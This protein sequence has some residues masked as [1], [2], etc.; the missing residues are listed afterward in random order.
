MMQEIARRA[1]WLEARYT[2]CLDREP[3][4]AYARVEGLEPSGRW[5]G[6]IRSRLSAREPL[7]LNHLGAYQ[8]RLLKTRPAK[9]A[10]GMPESYTTPVTST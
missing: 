5:H 1:P 7:S 8:F 10:H 6:R 3:R 4:S 2:H 9:L